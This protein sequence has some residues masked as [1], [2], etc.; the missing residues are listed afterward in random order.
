MLVSGCL[1]VCVHDN[2]KNFKSN[3]SNLDE[4]KCKRSSNIDK[5]KFMVMDAISQVWNMLE[6]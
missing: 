4:I 2:S 3:N 5:K 1:C 6:S